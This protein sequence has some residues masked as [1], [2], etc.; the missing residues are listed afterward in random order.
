MSSPF[1]SFTVINSNLQLFPGIY[2]HLQPL[3]LVT[4]ILIHYRQWFKA[5]SRYFQSFP[6]TSGHSSYFQ[7]C[8][9]ISS[10]FQQ[11]P[12]ISS[13]FLTFPAISRHSS[14][15]HVHAHAWE[16]N[17]KR[18]AF[19]QG[20]RKGAHTKNVVCLDAK[21]DFI[22]S[23][24]GNNPKDIKELF[25]KMLVSP[26]RGAFLINQ[27]RTCIFTFSEWAENLIF[28]KTLWVEI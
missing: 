11:F 14:H 4:S 6:A 28:F 13:N 9:A 15:F 12:A 2:S 7:Q 20:L 18:H 8:P 10:H 3:Q 23:G 5:I 22:Y 17:I 25:I 19:R 21:F 27:K 26:D 1:K 16:V 24:Q